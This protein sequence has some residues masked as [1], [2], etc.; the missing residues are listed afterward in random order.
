MTIWFVDQAEGGPAALQALL[1]QLTAQGWDVV[2]V[3]TNGINRWTVVA[4]KAA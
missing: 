1:Q 2:T 3:L 4:S